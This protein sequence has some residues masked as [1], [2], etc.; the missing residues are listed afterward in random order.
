MTKLTRKLLLSVLTVVLTVVALGTT[1]F[2]WFTLT[3]TAQIQSFD[4]EIIA[5]SGIEIA[6]GDET[7]GV[8]NLGLNWVTTLTS[9]TI[10]N[11]IATEYADNFR[12]NHVTTTDGITFRTLGIGVQGGT[13]P[14]GFLEL[15]IHFRSNSAEAIA[16]TG[17]TLS[18]T[19]FNWSVDNIFNAIGHDGTSFVAN[20]VSSVSND[21]LT[22][23]AAD[24]FRI[25]VIG[26]LTTGPVVKAYE[27]PERTTSP[28]N[29]YLGTGGIGY[30]GASVD[31]GPDLIADT[32][33]D[34]YTGTFGAHNYF[35]ENTSTSPFG[36]DNITTLATQT[37]I[38]EERV[39]DM[40]LQLD[41]YAGAA[42]Y[43]E[44]T[45]RIWLEGW[46]LN[47]YN[48]ILGQVISASFV[49]EGRDAE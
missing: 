16:W 37:S 23:N 14:S 35:Y 48:A 42:Y 19:D 24:A 6:I 38:N 1:T 46:D 12:F 32:A 49:F 15:P 22:L 8:D 17:V 5:D 43:G 20:P 29:H 26:T 36:I 2:A 3:N 30:Q 10:E 47:A 28:Y 33:D 39:L 18:A 44:I 31:A 25:A 27:K 41:E 9:E 40:T 7:L 21:I 45:I 11:Y 34:T 13:V 4:A